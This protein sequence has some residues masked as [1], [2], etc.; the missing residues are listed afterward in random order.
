MNSGV[1]TNHI[2]THIGF[3]HFSSLREGYRTS[4]KVTSP[5]RQTHTNGPSILYPGHPT[6]FCRQTTL[7]L[8]EV[9]VLFRTLPT[10]LRRLRLCP[11][12]PNTTFLYPT[13]PF[14]LPRFPLLVYATLVYRHPPIN[15][16]SFRVRITRT[17]PTSPMR[18]LRPLDL[19]LFKC[20]MNIKVWFRK[21]KVFTFF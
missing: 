17:E 2:I 13:I 16:F 12:S 20:S 3:Y 8:H 7:E 15:S 11:A 18:L 1:P 9:P 19:L 4:D 6:N 10:A 21:H 5:T 14:C